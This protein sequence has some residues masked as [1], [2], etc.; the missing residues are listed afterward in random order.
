MKNHQ[1]P[2]SCLAIDMGAGSI[3]IVQGV[4]DNKLTLREIYRFDNSMEYTDGAERW[5]LKAITG[6]IMY[7]IGKAFRESEI[8]IESIGVDSWGVDFVLLGEN[9]HPLE[10]P[11]SYRDG[12]TKGMREK[13]NGLMGEQ[14]TFRRTGINYNIFNSLYQL[15]SLKDSTILKKTKRILF[16]ADYIN[17]ILC[18]VAKNELALASTSQLVNCTTKTWDNEIA[19]LLGIDTSVF[20]LPIYPGQELGFLKGIPKLNKQSKVTAVAGHDT[21][22]AVA[23]VPFETNNS[24]FLSTG[25]WCILGWLSEKPLLSEEAYNLGITN[26]IAADGN[27][28]PVKNMMGLWLIQQLR[29]AFGSAHSYDEIDRMAGAEEPSKHLVDTAN[30]LFYNP[31]NMKAAFDHFFQQNNMPLPKSEASYYRCAYDSL[32]ASFRKTLLDFEALRGKPFDT[33]HV[34]GGGS[35]SELFCRLTANAMQ[36]KVIAGP[37][38]GAVAGNLLIQYGANESQ[39]TGYAYRDIIRQSVTTK[40]YMPLQD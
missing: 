18:G 40:Y 26:E 11:V 28:R 36:K 10:D 29:I 16:M 1:K 31:D 27:F 20:S 25:T 9:G 39:Q 15:L 38:E 17:Y 32:A 19:G 23:A 6:G 13:W 30:P 22:C 24:A 34:I 3:R 4:F 21:A 12:R 8:P 33:V 14:E 2:V 5:N 7:G 35:R 37:V